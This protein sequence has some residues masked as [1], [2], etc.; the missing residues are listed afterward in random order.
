MLRKDNEV[1]FWQG[2]LLLTT[3]VYRFYVLDESGKGD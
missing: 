1:W 2:E 3:F